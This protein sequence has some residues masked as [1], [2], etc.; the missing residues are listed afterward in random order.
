MRRIFLFLV[1]LFVAFSCNKSENDSEKLIDS[2]EST[3]TESGGQDLPQQLS[4]ELTLIDVSIKL[5]TESNLNLS[6]LSISSL[7]DVDVKVEN[8]MSKVQLIKNDGLEMLIVY[9]DNSEP[10]LMGYINPILSNDYEINAETTSIALLMLSSLSFELSS[11]EKLILMDKIKNFPEF[12]PFKVLV[13]QSLRNGKL[14]VPNRDLILEKISQEISSKTEKIEQSKYPLNFKVEEDKAIVEYESGNPAYAVALRDQDFITLE[15]KLLRGGEGGKTF[16]VEFNIPTNGKW[17][18]TAKNGFPYPGSDEIEHYDALY[19]NIAELTLRIFGLHS[20]YLQ[21]TAK[22]ISCKK[23]IGLAMLN[24][25]VLSESFGEYKLGAI[26][27]AELFTVWFNVIVNSADNLLGVIGSCIEDGA[28]LTTPRLKKAFTALSLIFVAVDTIPFLVQWEKWDDNIDFCF[29]KSENGISFCDGL[30]L[31]GNF[32]FGEV[33]VGT[34]KTKKLVISNFLDFPFLI[35]DLSLPEGFSSNFD[36]VADIVL[37]IAPGAEVTLDITFTPTDTIEYTERGVL[38]NEYDQENNK[39][40]LTGIGIELSSSLLRDVLTV[41]EIY[42]E[43]GHDYDVD[44]AFFQELLE[45]QGALQANNYLNSQTLIPSWKPFSQNNIIRLIEVEPGEYRIYSLNFG[46]DDRIINLPPEIGNLTELIYLKIQS[47]AMTVLPV[48]VGNLTNLEQLII[49]KTQLT[50][51][52]ME[53]GQCVNLRILDLSDNNIIHLPSELIE[54]NKLYN[55]FL[56]GNPSLSSLPCEFWSWEKGDFR[57]LRID[58]DNQSLIDNKI[59]C[60]EEL[61]LSNVWEVRQNYQTCSGGGYDAMDYNLTYEIIF[62]EDGYYYEYVQPNNYF[63]RGTWES[64]GE[65]LN[66]NQE[67]PVI[68]GFDCEG[69]NTE[70]TFYQLNRTFSLSIESDAWRRYINENIAIVFSSQNSFIESF[71]YTDCQSNYS[72]EGRLSIDQVGP[73]E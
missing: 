24:N 36:M 55:I 39:V 42:K 20:A 72:C 33:F 1:I 61:L 11:H 40:E 22:N 56:T 67:I 59:V 70:S 19:E 3:E 44:L 26:S 13:E 60:F 50:T 28:K 16:P 9:N 32:D 58:Q 62:S 14:E 45:Q 48:E 66:L 38:E 21:T 34:S 65:T 46:E 69:N 31:G 15:T 63:A 29:V 49:N 43:N 7:F 25:A 5:P 68:Y 18:L 52:P 30:V 41:K 54:I 47:S 12:E 6:D 53:I 71:N 37:E 51:V 57:L 4:Q 17:N 64:V 23:A 8:G 10:I 27:S 73:I 35:S 2:D